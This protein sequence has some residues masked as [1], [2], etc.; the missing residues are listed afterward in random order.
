MI[1]DSS[2]LKKFEEEFFSNCRKYERFDIVDEV[3]LKVKENREYLFSNIKKRLLTGSRED[4]S[5]FLENYFHLPFGLHNRLLVILQTLEVNETYKKQEKLKE[6]EDW[7]KWKQGLI[8][9]DQLFS[10][11]HCAT[12][13]GRMKPEVADRLVGLVVQQGGHTDTSDVDRFQQNSFLGDL[14]E[15][16]AVIPSGYDDGLQLYHYNGF[17]TTINRS[18]KEEPVSYTSCRSA[19]STNKF[20]WGHVGG[21]TQLVLCTSE[22][23]QDL[24]SYFGSPEETGVPGLLSSAPAHPQHLLTLLIGDSFPCPHG[25]MDVDEVVSVDAFIPYG[26]IESFNLV[27]LLDGRVVAGKPLKAPDGLDTLLPPPRQDYYDGVSEIAEQEEQPHSTADSGHEDHRH[28]NPMVEARR[29]FYIALVS[30]FR[31]CV[32]VTHVVALND[33]IFPD[34]IPTQVRSLSLEM[35]LIS[36]SSGLLGVVSADENSEDQVQYWSLASDSYALEK[37]YPASFDV[38]TDARQRESHS[39]GA[40]VIMTDFCQSRGMLASCD[41][42]GVVCLWKL[43]LANPTS[44][45]VLY[46]DPW[47]FCVLEQGD[48]EEEAVLLKRRVFDVRLSPSGEQLVVVLLDRL[49]LLSIHE[50]FSTDGKTTRTLYMRSC[51]DVIPDVPAT[52]AVSFR[53]RWMRIWR[54]TQ[55]P[56]EEEGS[57]ARM[58][59]VEE[60]EGGV[61]VT[62][63]LHRSVDC[64]E[65]RHPT[66]DTPEIDHLLSQWDEDKGLPPVTTDEAMTGLEGTEALLTDSSSHFMRTFS[67]LVGHPNG[68][69]YTGSA[70][71][72]QEDD[73]MSS[74]SSAADIAE[75][76]VGGARFIRVEGEYI[77]VFEPKAPVSLNTPSGT[78]TASLFSTPSLDCWTRLPSHF[79]PVP[80]APTC[81]MGPAAPDFTLEH[82]ESELGVEPEV[83]SNSLIAHSLSCTSFDHQHQEGTSEFNSFLWGP[84]EPQNGDFFDLQGMVR[85]LRGQRM[86]EQSLHYLR[87]MISVFQ[88]DDS[89]A[90]NQ[91][92]DVL[93]VYSAAFQPPSVSLLA[94]ALDTDTEEI[95]SLLVDHLSDILY[96]DDSGEDGL[97]HPSEQFCALAKWLG[98]SE[99]FRIGQDFWLDVAEGHNRLFALYLKFCG[100]KSVAVEHSWQDY[101]RTFGSAHLR[102]CSRG[103]RKYTEHIRKLDE[104]ANIR[105]CLPHQIGYIVG[106]QEIYARRVGL[107]GKIPREIGQLLQLRVLSMGNNKLYGEL[108]ASL[109]Q[110]KN[111]QRIVLH[112]NNLQGIV[113]TSLAQLG[114]IVNL[115]GNPRLEHGPDVPRLEREALVELFL[116]TKGHQWTSRAYWASSE[117]V[118]R[119]YKVGVLASHVHSIVMSSNGM[120]G[121]LPPSISRLKHLRMIE[122]ATMPDLVGVIPK[123]LCQLTSLR[124]LCICRC[125]LTGRIP[126]EIGQLVTLE[127]LQLFGNKLSGTVP[128]SL[129]NLV[130]LKLLSLGEYTGGNDFTPEPLPACFSKLVKLEALFMANCRVT[131]PF[132]EWIGNLKELRQLDLQRN[133]FY[134]GLPKSIGLLENLLY[135]NIKDNEGLCGQ[136]PLEQLLSLS[137]LNRLSLVHCNFQDTEMVLQTMKTHLPRCKVWI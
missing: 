112:Q 118:S 34:Q 44:K 7:E 82:F 125:G 22:D 89:A 88:T 71:T 17:H 134:G 74:D 75:I 55:R 53:G 87:C 92:K 100:N 133:Q 106:L 41:N 19:A 126:H 130:N 104:T 9:T 59:L 85:P 90:Y 3:A 65:R 73:R 128:E 35:V 28:F 137:R 43:D 39:A 8:S 4:L 97:V 78:T 45:G 67:N 93:V 6:P 127:E 51:L 37:L 25:T 60:K 94:A 81:I 102:R 54:V 70:S 123:E 50:E 86:Q 31:G 79:K 68:P 119:W 12:A 91:V 114:C 23:S 98:S 38:I 18:G 108:P 1:S 129:G 14:L 121:R 27:L 95:V 110:L 40:V 48:L 72:M 30:V 64:F 56:L 132:P 13:L 69:L 2:I 42:Q 58:A 21:I 15:I 105:T 80:N 36:G 63:W 76:F 135:L 5:D 24:R 109:G 77:P 11:I 20:W 29:H 124:R 117:P 66:E 57:E 99:F 103:L 101:L 120:R 96:I 33:L 107:S 122:L 10:S 136:L 61:I 131:G 111:L 47:Q 62:S 32:H 26:S 84:R 115:A 46:T 116:A 83:K 49:L 113:P 52:Y 16:K